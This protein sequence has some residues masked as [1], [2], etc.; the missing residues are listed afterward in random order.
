MQRH[1]YDPVRTKVLPASARE[2][3]EAVLWSTSCPNSTST[4]STPTCVCKEGRAEQPKTCFEGERRIPDVVCHSLES[5]PCMQQFG[6]M[7]PQVTA[8]RKKCNDGQA[9]FAVEYCFQD[10]KPSKYSAVSMMLHGQM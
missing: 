10:N 2:E 5:V 4:S 7:A 8:Y 6:G 3:A 9:W 1:Q